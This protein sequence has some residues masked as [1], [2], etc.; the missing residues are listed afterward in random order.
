MK[1]VLLI[2]SFFALTC[3]IA[4]ADIRLDEPP[5]NKYCSGQWVK[6]TYQETTSSSTGS[7][8]S[9]NYEGHIEGGVSVG[10]FVKGEVKAGGSYGSSKESSNSNNTS[11]TKTYSKW[12]CMKEEYPKREYTNGKYL[13]PNN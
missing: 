4:F 10:N 3:N 2:F 7:K 13:K 6:A 12:E 1:S 11:T 5:S 9:N 8:K